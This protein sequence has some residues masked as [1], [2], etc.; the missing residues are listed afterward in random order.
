[1][2]LLLLRGRLPAGWE[3]A[4]VLLLRLG[5]LLLLLGE[6]PGRGQPGQR[7]LLRDGLLL[8]QLPARGQLARSPP[9]QAPGLG[10]A[11][12]CQGWIAGGLLLGELEGCQQ[13]GHQ[14]VGILGHAGLLQ[15]LLQGK[16]GLLQVALGARVLEAAILHGRRVGA[17]Q[18]LRLQQGRSAL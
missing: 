10:P 18:P 1:M 15:G 14:V 17:G 2:L 12:G 9:R 8:G 3:L 13:V 11:V 6:L 5:R 16:R 4:R 7:L